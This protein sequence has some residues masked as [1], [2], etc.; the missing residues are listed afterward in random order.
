A[1]DGAL[2][3]LRMLGDQDHVALR[4]FNDRIILSE[5]SQLVRDVR[6]LHQKTVA[7]LW[8]YGGTHLYDAV[9]NALSEFAGQRESAAIQAVVVL[10]DG[11]DR[12]SQ[13]TLPRIL[14][15]INIAHA[16]SGVRVLTIAYGKSADTTTLENISG[17]TH[18]KCFEG[19]PATIRDV[20]RQIST[21][22]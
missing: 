5:P 3:L 22:F 13:T 7:A 16:E 4:V 11:M 12:G 1:Q 19:N 18:S 2:E 6:A 14:E 20:F 15:C 8:A 10:S 9:E 17:A 21:F